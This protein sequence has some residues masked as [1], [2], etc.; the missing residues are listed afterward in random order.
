MARRI[1]ILVALMVLMVGTASAQ[2]ARSALEA[3]MKAM[4]GTNLKSIQYSGGGWFCRI[5]QTYGLTEN[6]PQYEVADYTRVIDYDAKWSREDYTRRQ[7]KRPLRG[8]L[9]M[10]EEHVTSILSGKYAWDMK[11]DSPVLT[12]LYLYGIPYSDMR[13]LEL[14]MTPHG[15]LKAAL[16]ASDATA[17]TFPIVGPSD[18][19]FSQFGREVTIVSFTM[20][21]YR[22]NGTINDQNLVEVVDTWIPN[23]M[24]GDMNYE[25]RY[26]LYKDFG[27]V[28]FP[29][30]IHVHQG[31]PNLNPAHDYYEIDVTDVKPNLAVAKLSVPEMVR[32]ATVA[33]ARVES[34]KLADGVWL[35]GGGAHNSV[36]VE[37]KNFVAVVEAP[38]N[39]ERSLAV[40]AE[41]KRLVPNKLIRYVVN[42]HH[43]MDA[44]G[45]LRTYLAQ[46]TTIVTH[47]SNVQYYID[48]LF[49]PLPWTLK[50]DRLAMYNP[51]FTSE[52]GPLPIET[53]GGDYRHNATYVITDGERNMEIFHVQDMT[54]EMGYDPLFAQGNHSGDMLMAYLPKE[55]MLINA[56]LYSP[57]AP[58]TESPA[59]PTPQALTLYLNM[60]QLNLD[61]AEHVPI[62]GRP[63][64]NDDFIK[65]LGKGALL[66][67]SSAKDYRH[68]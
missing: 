50:P 61:V 11:G 45:G 31:D 55:K 43:H 9:P 24:Y 2:E 46:G 22:V 63:G 26:T 48:I 4:G 51:L 39:E 47:E 5:G 21:K 14:V 8:Q 58:G 17:A 37:F 42:T 54:L 7:G 19:G 27:G 35:L 60:R 15:F 33:P 64:T 44:A 12:G 59:S 38:E 6:W 30:M 18:F 32:T 1:S 67:P 41:A 36:L 16:A 28:K 3:A 56:D 20:G 34:Q 49:H 10:P 57:P 53:V 29:T 23:P 25:M 66:S 40:M 65:F 62:E 13:Q 52:R 68:P